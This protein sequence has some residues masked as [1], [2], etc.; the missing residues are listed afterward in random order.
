M[1]SKKIAGGQLAGE[2]ESLLD[3]DDDEDDIASNGS[4]VDD[5]E[6][7]ASSNSAQNLLVAGSFVSLLQSEEVRGVENEKEKQTEG[8]GEKDKESSRTSYEDELVYLHGNKEIDD[9]SRNGYHLQPTVDEGPVESEKEEQNEHERRDSKEK[10]AENGRDEVEAEQN[11]EANG[12]VDEGFTRASFGEGVS[13]PSLVEETPL[14][15]DKVIPLML[16]LF[17]EAF[18]S[19][20]IF[21]YVGYMIYD[22]HLTEDTRLLGYP[23]T[24]QF[25]FF[26]LCHYI[27]TQNK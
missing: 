1:W 24:P 25:P 8:I 15:K 2:G 4:L 11:S 21:P 23:L 19:N 26:K 10:E 5:D 27:L 6:I 12:R 3:K 20:S 13:S 17:M 16:M 7:A 14:P 22:F 18:N 9:I